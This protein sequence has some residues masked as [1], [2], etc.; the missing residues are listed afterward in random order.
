MTPRI[1]KPFRLVL[2]IMGLLAAYTI[3]ASPELNFLYKPPMDKVLHLSGSIA[4]AL[5][6]RWIL[7]LPLVPTLFV[8]ACIGGSFELLQFFIPHRTPSLEDFFAD[9]IG[10]IIAGTLLNV[11]RLRRQWA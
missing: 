1:Q 11:R 5:L 6:L 7:K 9:V 3:L 4:I 2:L 8:T 10:V